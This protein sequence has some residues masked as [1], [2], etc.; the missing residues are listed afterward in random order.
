MIISCQISRYAM[1]N[2][3]FGLHPELSPQ[4]VP[5]PETWRTSQRR[6]HSFKSLKKAKKTRP[7]GHK[8]GGGPKPRSG[9]P[10]VLL[11]AVSK[12]VERRVSAEGHQAHTVTSEDESHLEVSALK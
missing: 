11:L 1:E 3:P 5:V 2:T 7:G 4:A 12:E 8:L 9:K 10:I 6:L